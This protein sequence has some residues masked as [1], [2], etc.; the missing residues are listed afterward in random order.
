MYVE[1][2]ATSFESYK[3]NFHLPELNID[4]NLYALKEE[5]FKNAKKN[6]VL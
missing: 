5:V 6:I 4:I 1:F 2:Y 3:Y